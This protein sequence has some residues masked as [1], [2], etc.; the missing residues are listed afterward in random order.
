MHVSVRSEPD[1]IH[2]YTRND[3]DVKI[4]LSLVCYSDGML[5]LIS[6]RCLCGGFTI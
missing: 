5:I 6:T 3:S 1:W 4:S 2:V